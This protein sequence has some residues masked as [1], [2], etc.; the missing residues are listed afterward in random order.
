M[1][2]AKYSPA[3]GKNV[4][5]NAPQLYIVEVSSIRTITETANAITAITLGTGLKFQPVKADFD[6]VQYTSEG[7]FKTSGGETQNL[8]FRLSKPTNA[9]EVFLTSL[10]DSAPCGM[11]AVFVDGNRRAKAF[12]FSATAKEGLTRPINQVGV[13][14]D[15]GTLITDEDSQAYT[16]TLTRLGYYGPVPLAATFSQG[17][18]AGT[19]AWVGW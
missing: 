7:T 16:L 2:I 18:L 14:Y 5:G 11:V 13:S 9:T 6:S 3:C 17:L 8:I 4:P 1:A 15:S 12:G 19:A 10:K